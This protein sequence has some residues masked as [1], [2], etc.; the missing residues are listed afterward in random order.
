M[1]VDAAVVGRIAPLPKLSAAA[2]VAFK[3][4]TPKYKIESF[5]L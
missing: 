3:A 1:A 5:Q 4:L 2:V